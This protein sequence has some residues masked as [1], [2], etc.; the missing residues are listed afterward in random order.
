VSDKGDLSQ[1]EV[2]AVLGDVIVDFLCQSDT[3]LHYVT[4][5]VFLVGARTQEH[6]LRE[7]KCNVVFEQSHIV[8]VALKAVHHDE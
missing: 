8:R 3:H 1:T 2:R 6:R 4:L 5:C 7:E